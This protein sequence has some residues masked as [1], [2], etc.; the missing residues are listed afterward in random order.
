VAVERDLRL[1]AGL[2]VAR[3]DV[4]DLEL[5]LEGERSTTV[6]SG[7]FSAT[8]A[9]SAAA[10]FATMPFTGERPSARRRGA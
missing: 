9:F 3:V 10:R 2:D 6:R 1:H 8:L 7:A 4:G 5:D